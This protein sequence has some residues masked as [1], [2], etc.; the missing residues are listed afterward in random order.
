MTWRCIR[1]PVPVDTRPCVVCGQP[2]GEREHASILIDRGE[3][4]WAHGPCAV[5]AT[6][7]GKYHKGAE[8]SVT[9]LPVL[10]VV[11][12]NPTSNPTGDVVG[13]HTNQR[14]GA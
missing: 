12:D 9:A 4:R 10:P 5:S 7:G 6:K 1:T 11:G 2:I 3:F 13:R 14:E 8:R